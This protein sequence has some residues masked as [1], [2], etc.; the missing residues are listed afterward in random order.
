MGKLISRFKEING[1]T[2]LHGLLLKARKDR[3]L[4]AHQALIL[5]RPE[6]AAMIGAKALSIEAIREI[7][8]RAM[9]AMTETVC[10][11]IRTN[12][13]TSKP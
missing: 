11:F 4:I 2:S 8:A 7:D 13:P 6:M 3:N 10:E 9:K 1:N 5:Q 12:H